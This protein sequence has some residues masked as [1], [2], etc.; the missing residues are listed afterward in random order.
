M[1]ALVYKVVIVVGDASATDDESLLRVKKSLDSQLKKLFEESNV[2][3]SKDQQIH[4][5]ASELDTREE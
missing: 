5:V 1:Q 3:L 4:L 2:F